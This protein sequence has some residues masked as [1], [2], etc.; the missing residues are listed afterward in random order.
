MLKSIV[1]LGMM[2]ALSMLVLFSCSDGNS[3]SD[4]DEYTDQAIFTLQKDGNAGHYGCFEFV[5]P[6]TIQ[7]PDGAA[8]SV[9]SY[10]ELRTAIQTWKENNPGTRV[11]PSLVFPVEVV[12][13]DGEV[14]S[15]DDYT[16]L[17]TLASECPRDFFNR[18]HHRNHRHRPMRCFDLV[19]P[20]T[21]E[22]PDGS[23]VTVI[24]R[25]EF[26]QALRQWHANNPNATER[27]SLT[28][29]FTVELEDGSLVVI[30]DREELQRLKDSCAGE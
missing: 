18:R 23:T 11:F 20:L 10:E 26:K 3:L 16:E 30:D 19:F 5:F 13:Q 9:E 8:R 24:D 14:V 4:V 27:P 2:L 1:K 6:L 28:F 29:P 21:I 12:S 25:Q 22:F 7:F 17:R 15:L